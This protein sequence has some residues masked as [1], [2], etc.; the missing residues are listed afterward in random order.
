MR[1]IDA[2]VLIDKLK[3]WRGDEED[4]DRHNSNEVG[5]Y[6]GMSRAIMLTALSHTIDAVPVVR[7]KDCIHN[8]GLSSGTGW[9][10]D[11]IVCNYHMSDGFKDDDF[12]FH[13]VRMDG[14]E[15]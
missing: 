2:D 3:D 15:E 8:E 4:V 12:C 7:C 10:K 5:Y 14:E 9:C 11:D 1:L 13:G 6:E